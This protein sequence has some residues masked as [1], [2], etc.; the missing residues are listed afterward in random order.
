MK[1]PL[2]PIMF[3]IVY[4][5]H[6]SSTNQKCQGSVSLGLSKTTLGIVPP[7]DPPGFKPIIWCTFRCIFQ[8]R[9]KFDLVKYN[10]F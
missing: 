9:F 7:D 10:F 5:Q 3:N 2:F 8:A 4:S 1:D 6:A